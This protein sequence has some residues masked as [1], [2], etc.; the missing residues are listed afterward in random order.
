MPGLA[1]LSHVIGTVNGDQVIEFSRGGSVFFSASRAELQQ[2]WSEQAVRCRH[3]GTIRSAR[4]EFER[5]SAMI[6][7]Q[8]FR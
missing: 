8:V 1:I 4:E 3:C 6:K 7:T 5:V 2:A